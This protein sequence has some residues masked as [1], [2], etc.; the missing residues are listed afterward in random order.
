MVCRFCFENSHEVKNP[1]CWDCWK[2][3]FHNKTVAARDYE[4]LINPMAFHL[5]KILMFHTA[6]TVLCPHHGR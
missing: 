3:T 5:I 1:K 4:K 2:K 6:C